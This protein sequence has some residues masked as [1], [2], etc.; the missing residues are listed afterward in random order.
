MHI[1]KLITDDSYN[2]LQSQRRNNFIKE[3]VTYAI[4]IFDRSKVTIS[5]IHS[6]TCIPTKV[7]NRKRDP[8]I[9]NCTCTPAL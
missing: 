2:K 9:G 1:Y 8:A 3:Y 5:I 7:S 6:K 4:Y